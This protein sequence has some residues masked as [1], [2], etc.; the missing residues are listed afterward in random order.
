MRLQKLPCNVQCDRPQAPAAVGVVYFSKRFTA[1]A[2]RGLS[3]EAHRSSHL[4]S[5]RV[6]RPPFE[7][8]GVRAHWQRWSSP[9]GVE[10]GGSGEGRGPGMY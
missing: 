1:E 4:H 2:G 10:F 6:R 8:G 5:D 9:A 7:E 3:W